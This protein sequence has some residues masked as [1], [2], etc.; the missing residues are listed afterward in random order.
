MAEPL[1][2]TPPLSSSDSAS[3]SPASSPSPSPVS[4]KRKRAPSDAQPLTPPLSADDPK[5][6]HLLSRAVHVLSTAASALSQVTFLYQSDHVARHGL[7][8]AVEVITKNSEAGGKLIVCGVGKSGL[9]GRKIVATMKSLGIAS[10]FMHAAEA[11]HGDLGDIRKNDAVMFISYSGKT[12]ELVALLDHI[13]SHT[14]ILAITSHTKPSECPLLRGRPRS[15]LL[16][17]PIHEL[18]E[19]SFGVC[20]PTTSTTVTIA[21]GDMLAL[22]I[23]EAMHQED[24][25]I[26]FRRNHPGGAIGAKTRR[27]EE[28]TVTQA[29]KCTGL[30]TPPAS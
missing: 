13:P 8:Q 4:L 7:L 2:D 23:A 6:T 15:I 24:T 17:A 25:K 19:V 5:G 28:E 21:V 26:V 29:N 3:P 22:T 14:P 16:P 20:A 12:A 18:E 27:I 30:V 11:L 1:A 9:V 10:S